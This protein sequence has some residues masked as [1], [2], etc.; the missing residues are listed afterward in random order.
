L[1][2][3]PS[4]VITQAQSGV[5]AVVV[6]DSAN[7][8]I[9]PAFGAEVI[10]NVTAG[11][12]F[13]I[14]TGRSGDSQWLRVEFNGDE[15][16]V[17]VAPLTI[18]SGDVASL[19]VGDPRSIPYG[20]F[21]APRSG[22][23]SAT[24]PNQA[25]V[26]NGLRVR[27]GPGQGYPTL[28]NM[29]A[30]TIVPVF[31]RTLSNQWVQVNYNGTLGWVST[32]FLEFLNGFA[33]TSLPIDGIIAEAAPIV[34]KTSDD[35]FDTLRLMLARLDLA[36][37]SLDN[38]RAKWTDAALNGR[39]TCR[40]YPA[41]PSDISIAVPTL[42]AYNNIL[43]PLLH[44]FNDAMFNIRRA[45][46]LFI[47]VCN[48]PGLGNPVGSATVSGALDAVNVADSQFASLRARLKD[49][50]PPDHVLGPDECL[51]TWRTSQ[52]VLKVISLNQIVR[53]TF[54]PQDTTVGY[55]IDLPAGVSLSFQSLV[56][57]GSNPAPLIV[58]TPFDNPT[59]F[60]V[61][62]VADAEIPNMIVAPILVSQGGRYLLI[63]S[64]TQE[65]SLV[66][67]EI[68]FVISIVPASGQVGVL[69]YDPIN[70][71][72]FLAVTGTFAPT[73]TP[74]PFAPTATGST[75]QSQG[76]AVSC[77]SMAFVCSQFFSCDEARACLALGN[78]SLDPD[79]DGVP[80]N[81]AQNV[82]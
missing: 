3:L 40:D 31:G 64:A 76:Q 13:E 29:F 66:N 67:G 63:L 44:D 59:N 22:S 12:V 5:R 37:P 2:V 58:V 18:L 54:T 27:A 75:A 46:D 9:A 19:P 56:L 51:F 28:A 52:E 78:T 80:C 69:V 62:T 26:T 1:S 23:S 77:P 71:V 16:W 6:N 7:V 25:K 39:A 57:K 72:V 35:Y 10:A 41:R 34:G 11:Y 82:P 81:C 61:S 24:S 32:S 74:D 48:Q 4:A 15:G 70:D 33:I 60:L 55:C 36:Q 45:I 20:G 43:D 50:I 38:I 8:R 73:L 68:A 21:E 30:G 53:H 17:H 65:A 49:L 42:A 14:V 79:G 47:E